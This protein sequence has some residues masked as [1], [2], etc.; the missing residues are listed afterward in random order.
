MV[1]RNCEFCNAYVAD[2]EIH[3]CKIFG[4]QHH[5]SSA[6]LPRSCSG[7]IPEDI[8]LRTE[9]IHYEKRIPSI[10]QAH[11][12]CQHSIHLNICQKTECEETAAA[13]VS[14]QYEVAN[15]NPHNPEISDF[16]FPGMPRGEENLT[17]STYLLQPSEENSAIMDQNT[18]FC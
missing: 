10:T 16:L 1:I 8:D 9:Q 2:F 15:Q 17:K 7:N 3:T 14:S 5:Q 13:E 4:N 6:T 12:S 18:Q 11:S